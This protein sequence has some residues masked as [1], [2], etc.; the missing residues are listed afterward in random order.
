MEKKT[1]IKE[2][3]IYDEG[4]IGSIIKYNF[5]T[6]SIENVELKIVNIY[7]WPKRKYLLSS[8]IIHV[9]E[10]IERK[11]GTGIIKIDYPLD[12]IRSILVGTDEN[13]DYW[14]ILRDKEA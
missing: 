6:K 9:L 12:E 3:N 2:N 5:I 11:Y 7:S 8:T 1:D 14:Y 13:G 10:D 4:K